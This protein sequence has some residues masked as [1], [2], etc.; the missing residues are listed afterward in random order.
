MQV[1]MRS[2]APSGY[3]LDPQ[4]K[5]CRMQARLTEHIVGGP[6]FRPLSAGQILFRGAVCQERYPLL[7][8]S[9]AD[10]G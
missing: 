9:A 1:C 2:P 7:I 3:L 4:L 6:L 10:A 8:R 5:T